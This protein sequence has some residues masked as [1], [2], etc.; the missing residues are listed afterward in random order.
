M[1]HD[2]ETAMAVDEQ[3][4]AASD[5]TPAD[6]SPASFPHEDRRDVLL[7]LHVHDP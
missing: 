4:H 1:S 3:Q 7:V 5:A 6:G 2:E